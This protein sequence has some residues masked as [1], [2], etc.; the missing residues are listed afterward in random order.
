MSPVYKEV[1]CSLGEQR[2]MTVQDPGYAALA[3]GFLLRRNIP[4]WRFD[5]G[6]FECVPA[7]GAS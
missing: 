6:G 2:D 7:A 5:T 4:N 1:L 3:K